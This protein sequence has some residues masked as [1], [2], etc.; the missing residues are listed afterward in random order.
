[1]PNM[2]NPQTNETQD[3]PDDEVGNKKAEGWVITDDPSVAH[4]L[5]PEGGGT[6]EGAQAS[7]GPKT[8]RAKSS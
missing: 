8:G 1:M 4:I 3:V 5:N 2:T 6:T 7:E